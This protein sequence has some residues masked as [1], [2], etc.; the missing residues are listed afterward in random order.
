MQNKLNPYISLRSNA[1]EALEFYRHVFGGTY[2]VSTF[3]D[4]GLAQDP[5]D[6][7]KVMHG[8]LGTAE[9]WTLMVA[10]TPS[11]MPW[12]PGSQI[13]ISL[14]GD[15][16]PGLRGYWERLSEGAKITMPLDSAPWGDVFGMLTDRFGVDWMVNI[17]REQS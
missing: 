10:D 4:F 7:D 14:S 11:S 17:S 1:R 5:A 6:E 12:N 13:A 3:K 8:A 9:G 2:A 16:E 15:D